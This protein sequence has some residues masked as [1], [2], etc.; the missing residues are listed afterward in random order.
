[1]ST[2]F[3]TKIFGS[4]NDRLLKQYRSSSVKINCLD[5]E[6]EKLTEDALRATTKECKPRAAGGEGAGH[7]SFA[8]S[9]GTIEKRSSLIRTCRKKR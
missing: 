2:N 9:S 8:E 7:G 1:M 5:L 6:L 4:R 3:L